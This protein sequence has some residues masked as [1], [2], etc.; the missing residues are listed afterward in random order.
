MT[1]LHVVAMFGHTK[2]AELLVRE[3]WKADVNSKRLNGQTQTAQKHENK[4]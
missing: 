4:K 1:A 2:L 3:P